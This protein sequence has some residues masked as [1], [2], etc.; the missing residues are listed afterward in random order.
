MQ[1]HCLIYF[2]P[3]TVFDGSPEANSVLDYTGPHTAALTA[4]GKLLSFQPL[5]MPQTAVTVQTRNGKVSRSDGPF[6]ETKEI[7]GGTA[8]IEARD[9][10]E[11]IEI[12]AGFPHA[13]LGYIEVRPAIDFS[14]PRPKV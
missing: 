7:I 1:F 14:K 13:R 4:S 3:K 2:D 5:N 8:L 12:A 9:I 11:A 10:E 6:M